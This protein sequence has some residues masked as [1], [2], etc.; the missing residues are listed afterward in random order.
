[1]NNSYDEEIS[2]IRAFAF[3]AF[4]TA[5]MAVPAMAEEA[6]FDPTQASAFGA[7]LGNVASAEQAR[8]LLASQGYSGISPLDQDEDGRWIGTAVKDGKT[9]FVAI[10]LP[11]PQAE[12]LTE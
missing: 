10:A 11:R 8:V 4:A 6:R 12:A 5:A 2:M 7:E 3:A 1:V 9:V